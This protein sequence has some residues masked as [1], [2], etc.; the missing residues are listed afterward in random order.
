MPVV[1]ARAPRRAR[2]QALTV[3]V[4]G[5]FPTLDP[6]VAQ[7]TESISAVQLLYQPLF[8]YGAGGRL[9]GLLAGSWS[10]NHARTTLTVRVVAGARF[11]DGRPVAPADVVYS[12]ARMLRRGTHAPEA[13]AFAALHGFAA[14]RAGKPARGIA[15]AGKHRVVFR[16]R[17]PVA[18]FRAL[19]A[20]PSTAVVE[21]RRA[22]VATGPAWWFQHSVGSG[23][24]VLGSSLPGH[25][26]TLL[27]NTRYW[28]RAAPRLPVRFEI[29][30]APAQ[31]LGAF[32]AGRVAIL[33]A[34]AT[35]ALLSAR[36]PAG[37]RIL[38][39]P[40][41]GVAYLG[42]N[43][44]KPPFSNPLLRRAV[45]LALHKR[46]LLAAS[47]GAGRVAAGLLPPGIAGYDPALRP[48]PYDPGAARALLR[49]AGVQRPLAVQLLTIQ[50]GGTQQAGMTDAVAGEIAREL[51]A[52]GFKVAVQQDSWAQY[53]QGLRSG[54]ANLF[55]AVWLADYRSPQ[56]FFFNLLSPQTVG[57]G[58]AS[59]YRNKGFDAALARASTRRGKAATAAY[60]ALNVQAYRHLPMLPEFYTSTAV[61]VQPWVHPAA[62]RV[63]L[64]PPLMP[65]LQRVQVGG[66]AVGT[67]VA[68]GG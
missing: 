65:R 39:G 49:S 25:S 40:D 6:A 46:R 30:S 26:L 59:F 8:S 15:V 28:R 45:A 47:G 63:F 2:P 1:A 7:D 58:N 29:M 24:Y 9:R 34:P 41:L 11:S 22:L 54:Q 33:P 44:A 35:R 53:Y 5:D 36:L 55:Q 51:D 42:F 50:A 62:F 16:L 60:R 66:S 52:V 23:P 21:R 19:L 38:V 27:P 18:D 61:L 57:A 67:A 64:D 32:D 37:S 4:P 12:L 48:Y 10:W 31:Q 20:L 17:Q 68:G 14:L 13:Q 43:T 56:D 3:A